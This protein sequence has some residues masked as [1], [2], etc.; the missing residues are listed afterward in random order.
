MQNEVSCQ[1]QIRSG[2]Q[3]PTSRGEKFDVVLLG[4]IA[5]DKLIMKVE[6]TERIQVGGPVYYGSFPLKCMG[7][8]VAVVTKLAREDFG[9]LNDLKTQG[10]QV[11]A[12]PASATSGMINIHPSKN[13]DERIFKPLPLGEPFQIEEIPDLEAKIWHIDP[14]IGGE[15][16]LAVVEKVAKKGAKLATDVQGFIRRIVGDEVKYVEWKEK[17]EILKHIHFLKL[18]RPEAK[19]LTGEDDLKK[20]AEKMASYGPKEVLITE[21]PGVTIY[22]QGKF[23]QAPFK[24]REIKGRTGRGDTCTSSYI[25]RRLTQPPEAACR[26]AAAVVSAKLET[27]GPFKGDISNEEAIQKTLAPFL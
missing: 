15:V 13:L 10:I 8:K 16:P 17:E 1:R 14:L 7:L 18:D 26:F 3:S 4:H 20:A 21:S 24:P 27:P 5:K 11:F 6:G 25:G 2:G 23:F 9:I 22:A 19:F 12:Y